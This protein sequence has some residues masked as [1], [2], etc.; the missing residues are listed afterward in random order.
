GD[1]SRTLRPAEVWDAAFPIQGAPQGIVFCEVS[2]GE[3]FARTTMATLKE[4]AYQAGGRFGIANYAWLQPAATGPLLRRI[5]AQWVRICYPGAPGHSP[6]ELDALG[7]A[8]NVQLGGVIFNGTPEQVAA[9]AD[10]RAATAKAA[11]A[12]Y[13]EVA[14]ELNNPWM[15]GQKVPEYIRDG[16]RPIAER[17]KGSGIKIMN[18]GL[19][20]MDTVWTAK[21]KE[22]GGF[23]LI[24]AFAFHPGR[25]NFTPDYAPPPEEWTQGDNGTYWNFLGALKE[26][27]RVSAGKELWLT[28]AYACTRPNRWWNDSHRQAAENV[29][30]TLALAVSEGVTGLNWY[31]PHDSTIHHPQEADPD[32]AEYHFGLMNRDT[33][34]KAALLAFAT[35]TRTLEGAKFIKWRKF[36]D[37]DVKGLQFD[38]F[39]ILWTRKDGYLQNA[40]HGA[41]PWYPHR[42]AWAD[43]W[44]TKTR[45]TVDAK[46]PNVHVVD[47]IGRE[48]WVPVSRG[49]ATLTLDG[50][51]RIYYGLA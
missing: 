26:A 12:R 36:H 34:V 29:L 43:H 1:V 32:N 22:A 39:S 25:G 23:D 24:D 47:C 33:S 49:R 48:T 16:L 44:P 3:E 9:W 31:Q 50:A 5:G 6:A 28:E 8:H 10:D 7:I 40:D 46:G 42:E 17:L 45:V 20:G 27:R 51:P 13:F 2:A 35:A 15:Q 19:G 41:D 11:G 30:L 14:N 21:F 4:H 37:P 18:C 38:G